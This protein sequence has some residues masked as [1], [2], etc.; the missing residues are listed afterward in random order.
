MKLASDPPFTQSPFTQPPFAQMKTG[1]DLRAELELRT[2][3]TRS[4]RAY[5][6]FRTNPQLTAKSRVQFLT[7]LVEFGKNW[8]IFSG[9]YGTSIQALHFLDMVAA[10]AGNFQ[11][12]DD[13]IWVHIRAKAEEFEK[14]LLIARAYIHYVEGRLLAARRS[15]QHTARRTPKQ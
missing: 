4:G 5:H 7:T 12:E 14:D 13:R 6:S 3:Y 10:N 1:A 15:A 11:G 8:N 9:Y 2:S